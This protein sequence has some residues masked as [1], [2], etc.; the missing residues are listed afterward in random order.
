[1]VFEG[2]RIILIP[3]KEA[4]PVILYLGTGLWRLRLNL[5]LVFHFIWNTWNTEICTCLSVEAP[6]IEQQ[7]AAAAAAAANV[8][9]LGS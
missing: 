2:V 6:A 4:D 1:M 9:S 8:Y 5:P 3:I 7:Q